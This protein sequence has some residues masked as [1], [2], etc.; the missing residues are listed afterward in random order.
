MGNEKESSALNNFLDT[1]L[2]EQLPN[3][4]S[5][6]ARW[7]H[8]EEGEIPSVRIIGNAKEKLP[9][10]FS[11]GIKKPIQDFVQ[12]YGTNCSSIT[13]D[14]IPG[15][16]DSGI[17]A[18][19][20][21]GTIQINGSHKI[22]S[23]F[24]TR[25]IPIIQTALF[26]ECFHL[27]NPE[28]KQRYNEQFSFRGLRFFQQGKDMDCVLLEE[29]IAEYLAEIQY[30]DEGLSRAHPTYVFYRLAVKN[31]IEAGIFS[32]DYAFQGQR[33]GIQGVRIFLQNATR[34][35]NERV[36]VRFLE[37]LMKYQEK[38]WSVFEKYEKKKGEGFLPDFWT[39]DKQGYT[40]ELSEKLA[41]ERDTIIAKMI[42]ELKNLRE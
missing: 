6:K 13:V 8:Y 18:I 10:Y 42:A 34:S 15:S 17:F 4:G 27:G 7:K 35:S 31:C 25:A 2:S 20:K 12:Q 39:V 16:R 36:Q 30:G 26:H 41:R 24:S 9:E 3:V 40:R 22:F 32:I 19:T 14:V 33:N 29:G 11:E 1:N 21:G 5:C 23:L 37:T 38:F 28:K